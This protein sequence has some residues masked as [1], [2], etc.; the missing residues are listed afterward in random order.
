MAIG[1][2]YYYLSGGEM[3]WGYAGLWPDYVLSGRIS[4][5]LQKMTLKGSSD[6]SCFYREKSGRVVLATRSP[7][8]LLMPTTLA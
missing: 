8:L 4:D 3:V 2:Y 1:C 7:H 6:R 5:R